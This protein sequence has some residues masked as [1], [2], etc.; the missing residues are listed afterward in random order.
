M[1]SAFVNWK[2]PANVALAA[3]T[4]AYSPWGGTGFLTRFLART[5]RGELV[6]RIPWPPVPKLKNTKNNRFSS[7]TVTN[8]CRA[9]KSNF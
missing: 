4:R 8:Q 2:N 3:N 5:P 6:R 1:K 9:A 7:E